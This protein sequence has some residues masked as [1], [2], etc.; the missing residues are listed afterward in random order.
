MKNELVRAFWN[1]PK[2]K[3]RGSQ[4]VGKP[5]VKGPPGNLG[6]DGRIILNNVKK[7]VGMAWT[8]LIWL[9]IGKSGKFCEQSNGPWGFTK[10]KEFPTS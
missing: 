9:R 1:V 8:E 10:C 4:M 6:V 2:G 5:E 3:M 7:S